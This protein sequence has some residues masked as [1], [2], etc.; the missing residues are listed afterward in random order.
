MWKN[1]GQTNLC[2]ENYFW[3][4]NLFNIIFYDKFQVQWSPQRKQNEGWSSRSWDIQVYLEG[5]EMSPNLSNKHTNINPLRLKDS[6]LPSPGAGRVIRSHHNSTLKL[7]LS[8]SWASRDK[9]INRQTDKHPPRLVERERL[10]ARSLK[11][12][13]QKLIDEDLTCNSVWVDQKN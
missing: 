2:P 13:H 11:N 9:E 12:K 6:T 1:L 5:T 10:A 7:L 8:C 4:L 3:G